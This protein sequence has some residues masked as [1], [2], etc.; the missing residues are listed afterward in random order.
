MH[1]TLCKL[2][3]KRE[4]ERREHKRERQKEREGKI[5]AVGARVPQHMLSAPFKHTS[6]QDAERTKGLW[7]FCLE[8]QPVASELLVLDLSPLLINGTSIIDSPCYKG[9]RNRRES[10]Q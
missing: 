10:P 6:P 7:T 5:E 8:F 9:R 2:Y 4:K 3:F 1:F